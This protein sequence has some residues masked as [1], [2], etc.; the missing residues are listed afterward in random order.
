VVSEGKKPRPRRSLALSYARLAE[1]ITQKE[2][3]ERSGI[4]D[5]SILEKHRAPDAETMGKLFAALDRRLPE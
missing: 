2:L 5:I 1:D 3:A 4:E